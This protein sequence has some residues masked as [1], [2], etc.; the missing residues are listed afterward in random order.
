MNGYE[1]TKRIKEDNLLKRTPVIMLTAKSDISSKIEGMEYGADDYLTKPFNSKELLTRIKMLLKTRSYEYAIEKRNNEIEDELRIAR[2]IQRK[3]LPHNIP[4]ISGF[5]FHPT[6]IPMDKVGGDFYD[7]KENGNMIEI[8]IAD[9]SGHGLVS[10]FISMI[11]KMAYDSIYD[12]NSCTNV[13]AQ[14]NDILCNSTVNSI[15]MTTFFCL[16]ERESK[17]L[18][19]ANAGHFYPVVYRKNTDEFYELKAKGKPLGWFTDLQ[20]AE[21]EMQLTEGDRVVF[22]TDGITECMNTQNELYGENR[23]KEFIRRNAVMEP[24]KFS[25]ILIEELKS[26]CSNEKFNDDLC[27]LVFDVC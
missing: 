24:E 27:L 20:L 7:F 1:M 14:L 22:Y 9:V 13:L 26:F 23:F 21:E 4:E 11:A 5:R 15:Y 25:S 12:K 17:K 8:F 2:L 18:K 16:I 10:A 6:Y 3:L 19:Y